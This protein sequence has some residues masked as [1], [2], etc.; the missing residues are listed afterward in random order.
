MLGAHIVKMSAAQLQFNDTCAESKDGPTLHCRA[1]FTV[2]FYNAENRHQRTGSIHLKGT[3]TATQI[4]IDTLV[5]M[6]I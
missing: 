2:Y 1:N 4:T 3:Y 6:D 5:P